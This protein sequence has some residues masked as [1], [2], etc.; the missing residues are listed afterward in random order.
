MM[1][2]KS[3]QSFKIC[4]VTISLAK[5]GA[6]RSCAMLSQMLFNKGH[7]VHL[8]VLNNEIDFA[9][10]GTLLNLGLFKK[11]NRGLWNRFLRFKKL[12]N[13]LV[14]NSFDVLI[15][16]RP[17]IHFNKEWIYHKFIY[18]NIKRIYVAHTSKIEKVL[19]NKPVKF[20][21]ILNQNIVN[22]S[23]SEYIKNENFIM[24]GVKKAVVI[25]NA[26]DS[27]WNENLDS[28]L[29]NSLIDKDYILSY[30]R[31][32]DEIKDFRFLIE[33]F[34]D[35]KVWKNNKYLIIMGDGKDK[36]D[37]ISFSN[38]L[39]CS[40]NIIF[41]PFTK[42]PF[43]I[44]SHAKFVTITSKY[45]GFPM[46]LA[47]SLSLGTPVVSLD[48]VSG[49][50]EIILDKL[51]GLLIA[52]RDVSLFSEG[53]TSMFNNKELYT[54]CKAN[55]KTSVKEFSMEKTSDKWNKLLQDELR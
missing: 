53:I 43:S 49:P 2:D 33:S 27:K 24:K 9:Y 14:D 1:S 40:K 39:P 55:G 26:F 22:V 46:I 31:I 4:L 17:K 15:D 54:R 18:R 42:N 44:I 37:L 20:V 25:H 35:S 32:D 50:S 38:L 41:L 6:E 30:G 51:N 10:K 5:G 28:E 48:I 52:K 8:V 34:K 23:V 7:E 11:N 12:R 45:E 13:Y 19:T 21:D 36:E 29:P 16:H 3:D 47:E